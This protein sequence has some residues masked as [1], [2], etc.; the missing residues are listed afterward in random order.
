ML[1]MSWCKYRLIRRTLRRVYRFCHF[2]PC[3]KRVYPLG[4]RISVSQTAGKRTG[5]VWF[6]CMTICP[7]AASALLHASVTQSQF[8]PL[9]TRNVSGLNHFGGAALLQ[10]TPLIFS[11]IYSPQFLLFYNHPIYIS[12]I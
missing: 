3:E 9:S 4:K 12:T 8:I 5:L 10:Y 2:C 6:G 11:T 1:P 7:L